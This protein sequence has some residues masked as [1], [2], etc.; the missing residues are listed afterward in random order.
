[1]KC[2]KIYILCLKIYNDIY[3]YMPINQVVYI[4]PRVYSRTYM[5]DIDNICYEL[6]L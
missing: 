3:I 6:F 1:M 5:L 2:I 4:L